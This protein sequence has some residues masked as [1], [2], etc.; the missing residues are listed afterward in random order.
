MHPFSEV[1]WICATKNLK[2]VTE[3][4]IKDWKLVFKQFLVSNNTIRENS[5]KL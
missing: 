5:F 3:F 2:Q 1:A 4:S